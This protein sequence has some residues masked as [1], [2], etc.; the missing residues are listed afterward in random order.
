IARGERAERGAAQRLDDGVGG[1][2]P[3]ADVYDGE[4]APVD[5]DGRPER[6]VV[7]HCRRVDLDARTV[8]VRD[9]RAHPAQLLDDP[10]EHQGPISYS[11]RTSGPTRATS[12]SSKRS[13]S[14][15][16]AGPDNA[17]AGTPSIPR[18]A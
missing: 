14:S 1:P 17:N 4:T 5:R 8:G 10:G 9:D 3:V 15:I 6:R 16:D 7:E 13:A 12:T 2:P 11:R 18:N